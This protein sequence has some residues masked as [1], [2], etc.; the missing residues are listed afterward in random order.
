MPQRTD[1]VVDYAFDD[2]R[3]VVTVGGMVEEYDFSPMPE[4]VLEHLPDSVL[5]VRVLLGAERRG[6]ELYVTLLHPIPAR[7]Q[8]DDYETPE[9]YQQ[10]LDEWRALWTNLEEV[11]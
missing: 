7:P 8:L 5:P 11:R 4:G 3:I 9:A 2:E 10:A 1:A 6:G